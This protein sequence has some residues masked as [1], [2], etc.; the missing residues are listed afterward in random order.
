M[1]QTGMSWPDALVV[2]AVLGFVL[3][4]LWIVLKTTR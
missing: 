3:G 1:T 4:M 2:V